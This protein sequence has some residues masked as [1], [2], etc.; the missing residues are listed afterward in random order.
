MADIALNLPFDSNEIKDILVDEFRKRLNGL[1][2]LQG[3]KEYSAFKAKFIVEISVF[4]PGDPNA[5][6]TLAWNDIQKPAEIP[7]TIEEIGRAEL[8]KSEYESAD[9]NEEREQRDMPMTVERSDGKGGKVR[10][11]VRI[12]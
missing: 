10:D 7:S 2:P 5:T 9:P 4:R 1:T 11:K 6:K 8:S 12:K 3:A